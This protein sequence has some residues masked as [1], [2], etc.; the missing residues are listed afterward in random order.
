[1]AH[2]SE[3]ST[4]SEIDIVLYWESR[5]ETLVNFRK[6]EQTNERAMFQGAWNCSGCGKDITELPFEPRDT[7][8][9]MCRD[10]FRESRGGGEDRV[11]HEGSWKCS[12][13]GSEITQLP[14]QPREESNLLCRDCFRKSKEAA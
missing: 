12:G 4:A 10:C 3:N 11:M 13:C 9:L 8:N 2:Y 7:S 6:V 5:L 14:F 1:V